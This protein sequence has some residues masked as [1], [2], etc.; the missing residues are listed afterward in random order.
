MLKGWVT[1]KDKLAEI[2]PHQSGNVY[3]YDYKTGLMAKGWTTI[4][5]KRYFFNEITGVLEQS[6]G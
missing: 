2:Y 5:G 4:G 3:Y 6:E 1:I